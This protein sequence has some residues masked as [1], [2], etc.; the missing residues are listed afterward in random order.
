METKA[1]YLMIATLFALMCV[2]TVTA[3]DVD[4]LFET[5]FEDGQIPPALNPLGNWEVVDSSI[6][7]VGEVKV[8]RGTVRE[9]AQVMTIPDSAGWDNYAWEMRIK[10]GGNGDFYL[11]SRFDL[12]NANC[13]TGFVMS[14]VLPED[15]FRLDAVSPD[16]N[17]ETLDTV[18]REALP[19]DEWIT[20]RMETVDGRT[21][22]FVNN[23][24]EP[25]LEGRGRV[26]RN[27]VAAFFLFNGASADIDSMRVTAVQAEPFEASVSLNDFAGRPADVVAELQNLGLAPEGGRRLFSEPYVFFSGALNRF[28]PLAAQTNYTNIVMSGEMSFRVGN[29]DVIE[30]CSLMSR[31]GAGGG[32]L[33]VQLVNEGSVLAVDRGTSGSPVV[34]VNELELDLSQPHHLLVVAVDDKVN[35]FVDGQLVIEDLTVEIRSGSFGLGLNGRGANALCEGRNVWVYQFD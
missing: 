33:T 27:G 9:I 32:S 7:G 29:P 18:E 25:L 14:L 10:I 20:L 28:Y 8:L 6:E 26:P 23:E 35:V 13:L 21:A 31:V 4:I 2:P 15:R 11:N 5:D 17:E 34:E 12:E 24:P 3:Q 1:L 30:T 22:I 19:L 16:C